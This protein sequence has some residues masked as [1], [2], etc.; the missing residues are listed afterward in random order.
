MTSFSIDAWWGAVIG[1]IFLILTLILVR[2]VRVRIRKHAIPA[3]GT[4]AFR[5]PMLRTALL[6]YVVALTLLA[7]FAMTAVAAVILD[8]KRETGALTDGTSGVIVLDVSSSI[9]EQDYRLIADSLRSLV[10][11]GSRTRFGL[12]FFSDTAYLALPPG[13][14]PEQLVPFIERLL[15]GEEG[16]HTLG[17]KQTP[18]ARTFTSGTSISSGIREARWALARYGERGTILLFSDLDDSYT[19][20]PVLIK[21]LRAFRD[22][23]YAIQV[24]GLSATE[25]NQR[26][27]SDI[28]GSDAVVTSVGKFHDAIVRSEKESTTSVFPVFLVVAIGVFVILLVTLEHYAAPLT[29]RR[30]E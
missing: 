1:V 29:W 23:P 20:L 3:T 21:F 13:T 19:D 5:R 28:L 8:Q 7:A 18:W 6:R 16:A 2:I 14:K 11:S 30:K 24:V 12:V 25:I 10:R 17:G 26:L 9:E 27:F 22:G 15:P 4:D